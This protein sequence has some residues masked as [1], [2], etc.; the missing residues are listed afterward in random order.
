MGY[1]MGRAAMFALLRQVG[2]GQ[3]T[4][5]HKLRPVTKPSVQLSHQVDY[6]LRNSFRRLALLGEFLRDSRLDFS[7]RLAF[8]SRRQSFRGCRSPGSHRRPVFLLIER[9]ERRRVPPKSPASLLQSK[10]VAS[11]PRGRVILLKRC[12]DCLDCT[13]GTA[14]MGSWLMR[15]YSAIT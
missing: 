9:P 12:V 7:N 5:E 8:A 14:T 13:Q 11:P 6:P 2:I 10:P 3:G 4:R 1:G 15:S